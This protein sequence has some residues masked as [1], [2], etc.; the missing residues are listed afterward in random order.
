MKSLNGP[1]AQFVRVIFLF[2]FI[3]H[4][5]LL[6]TQHQ[7]IHTCV[8]SSCVQLHS[9]YQT[10]RYSNV[11][12]QE[13]DLVIWSVVFGLS[14]M[15]QGRCQQAWID[16]CEK[17]RGNNKT[18]KCIIGYSWNKLG[19]ENETMTNTWIKNQLTD[20]YLLQKCRR[21]VGMMVITYLIYWK[22][23]T[24]Y[25]F[26]AILLHLMNTGPSMIKTKNDLFGWLGFCF[27]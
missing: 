18:K 5:A 21:H 22:W 16:L 27:W 6:V 23:V 11:G 26:K 8:F 24:Y 17:R 1:L 7:P 9:R 13:R 10:N 3:I 19:A 15:L 4:T 2:F 12:G 20:L 14:C 25:S